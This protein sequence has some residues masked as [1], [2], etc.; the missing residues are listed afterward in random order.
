MNVPV[1]EKAIALEIVSDSVPD[2]AAVVV[3][4]A[5]L[6]S[7][8]AGVVG[9]FDR[10]KVDVEPVAPVLANRIESIFTEPM[11]LVDVV[12]VGVPRYT[13]ENVPDVV[14]FVVQLPLV[15]QLLLAAVPDQ[16][17]VVPADAGLAA[18]RQARVRSV[19]PRPE[20]IM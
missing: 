17:V 7:E 4:V 9:V 16:V 2:V 15:D 19:L 13:S 8:R 11:S 5:P 1:P 14:G 3:T 6:R 20:G 12:L 18:A 10:M